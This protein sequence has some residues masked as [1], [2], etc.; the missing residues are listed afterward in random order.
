MRASVPAAFGSV[1]AS[2]VGVGQLY[3]DGRGRRPKKRRE[4]RLG[5]RSVV[6][7]HADN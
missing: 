6:I 2:L 4:D 1:V 7:A 3:H 5:G